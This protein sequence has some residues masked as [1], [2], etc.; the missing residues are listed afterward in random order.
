[1]MAVTIIVALISMLAVPTIVNQ[2]VDKKTQIDGATKQMIFD[3]ATLYMSNNEDAYPKLQ[4]NTYCI[5]LDDLV[6]I[7]YLQTPIKDYTNGNEIPLTKKI[8]VTVNSY[9]EYSNFQLLDNC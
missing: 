9:K 6:Q 2:I 1:M 7:G 5:K 8:K 3:A 4:G